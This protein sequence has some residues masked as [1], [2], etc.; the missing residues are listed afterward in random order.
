[1]SERTPPFTHAASQPPEARFP[2][3]AVLD[4]R[5][6]IEDLIGKGGMGAVYR[7][8]HVHTGRKVA[9]KV[10]HP[11][12]SGSAAEVERFR[13]E[14]RIAVQLS[15]PHVVEVLDFGQAPDGGL[16]L[17]MELLEGESV[18][19]RLDRERRLAPDRVSSLL[20]QLLRG[21]D[22]AHRAGIVHRD[23]KPE[24]LWLAPAEGGERLKILDFGVSKVIYPATGSAPT[25]AGLVLGTPE[26]LAPEQALGVEVDQRADI[27]ATGIIAW[28]LLTGRH[29]FPTADAR[30]LLRAHAFEPVPS[31][32]RES[33]EL[34]A[35]PALLRLVARATEK[36][37]NL[38]AQSAAELLEVLEGRAARPGAPGGPTA[39]AGADARAAPP[40]GRRTRRLSGLL[41]PVASGT[42][43]GRNLTILMTEI[44][45][46]AELAAS[47]SREALAQVLLEH[48]RAVLG[49]VHAYEGRRV[50]SV[51]ELVVAVFASPTNAVLCAMAVQDRVAERNAAAS[52]ADRIALRA[53][54][55]IGETGIE[56]GD[57]VGEPLEVT[58]A[59]RRLA[60]AGEVW[61]TRPLYLAMS[62][63][64][65]R[66]EPLGPADVGAPEQLPL[67]RVER[68]PGGFPYGGREAALVAKSQWTLRALEP[69]ADGVSSI[70]EG[71]AE[72]RG[73]AVWRVLCAGVALFALRAAELGA[74]GVLGLMVAATWTVWRGK[75][76]PQ[77]LDRAMRRLERFRDAVRLV[78]PVYRAALIRPLV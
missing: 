78:R 12:F 60:A 36:D 67:Y 8:E 59:V 25:Q 77:R 43:G 27:Y 40:L 6:R 46:Y 31:P 5:Y 9:V 13:R 57:L 34:A 17:V 71:A 39:S 11:E 23:L 21:L 26:Y 75:P 49:A 61:L 10:L 33:P 38:R 28:V 2:A 16:Y 69:I 22:A 70:G 14:A 65:V 74:R 29:P 76:R 4:D 54:L 68:A 20:R 48:D 24:N 1:M 58:A 63:S 50:K 42:P 32:E 35:Y 51:A 52:K 7:A 19:A 44:V 18:R 56:H 37:R 73:R 45:G 41:R 64:E 3:G 47:R 15:S 55:H 66:L 62:R 53:A 30:A 72:G